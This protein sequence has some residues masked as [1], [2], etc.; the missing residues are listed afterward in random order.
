MACSGRSLVE[1]HIFWEIRD[2]Q[3]SKLWDEVWQQMYPLGRDARIW[4]LIEVCTDQGIKKV[5]DLWVDQDVDQ[6]FRVWP[7]WDWWYK[8]GLTKEVDRVEESVVN[9][10]IRKHTREDKTGWGYKPQGIFSTKE[11]YELL[12]EAEDQPTYE[13]WTKL[14]KKKIWP[15]ITIFS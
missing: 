1:D 13:K 11:Y 5:A 4:Q 7:S 14:W 3:S 9:R 8:W 2:D 6:H 12:I 15:K 10:Q